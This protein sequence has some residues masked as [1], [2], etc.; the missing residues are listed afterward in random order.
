M[1]KVFVLER[2]VCVRCCESL[3]RAAYKRAWLHPW[4][5]GLNFKAALNRIPCSKAS[6]P[7]RIE[8]WGISPKTQF[9]IFS[10]VV[11]LCRQAKA[12]HYKALKETQTSPYNKIKAHMFSINIQ[13]RGLLALCY[14]NESATVPRSYYWPRIISIESC[15]INISG[16]NETE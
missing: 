8:N 13:W 14:S 1:R 3:S 12:L 2:F 15:F 4:T 16:K 10:L 7:P 9:T 11:W 5:H 6:K